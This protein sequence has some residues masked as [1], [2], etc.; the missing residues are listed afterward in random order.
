M[1][2]APQRFLPGLSWF[3]LGVAILVSAAG[4]LSLWAVNVEG[5]GARNA[6]L[7]IFLAFAGTAGLMGTTYAA[8]VLALMGIAALFVHRDSGL[9]ILAAGVACSIPIALLTL[10]ERV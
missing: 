8:P 7:A 5:L 9:R 1:G 3:L 6:G 10:L 4:L 2:S